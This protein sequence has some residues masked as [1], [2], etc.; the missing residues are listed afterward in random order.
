LAAATGGGNFVVFAGTGNSVTVTNLTP[1]TTYYFAVFEFNGT[2]TS[3]DY[4]TTNPATGSQTT[5]AAFQVSGVVRSRGGAGLSGVTV[6]LASGD[7]ALA[8]SVTDANGNYSFPNVQAGG[9]YTVTPSSTSFIFSPPSASFNALAAN[10]TADFTGLPRVIISE[11]R[12]HGVDPDGAGAATASANEFIE[13]YNQT[14]ENVTVTGWTLR[15]SDGTTLLTLPAAII[16]ARGHYLVAGSSYGLASYAAA[17]STLAADIPD[18][19]GVALFNNNTTFDAGTRLDA[20][21]FSGVGDPNYRESAGLTPAGGVVEDGE[22]SFVRRLA[23]GGVPADTD[24]NEADFLLVS[25]NGG[26][27]SSRQ[28]GLGAPGPENTSSPIQRNSQVTL[29]LLDPAHSSSESPNRTRDFTSDPANN[30][31]FGT[32]AIRRTLMNNTGAS[33]TR[34][35][36]RIVDVTTYP[37]PAGTADLRARTSGPVT[38]SVSGV[39]RTV[40]GTTLEEPPAQASG[41][42]NNSTLAAGTVTLAAPLANSASIDLQFLLGVQASGYFRF[43]VNVEAV[44]QAPVSAS[45]HLTMG[46]PSNAVTDVNQPTNFLMEKPQYVLAYHRDRGT[47]VWT[48]WHLDSTWLGSAPRQN[49]F[50]ADTTL[51]AGWYQVQGTDY[52]GSGFDRGHMTPSADRTKTVSDNSATFLM[53]NMIPQLPANNQGPWA[54]LESYARTL[55][56]AGNEL[57]IISGGTGTQG[58]IASGHVTVPTQTWKVIMVL[59]VGT[60]DVS[61]VTTSTRLIAVIM[62][63][64]GTINTDWRTYRVSVDQ[65]E[66]LT[67]FDFFSN[68]S[69]AIQSSIEATV[70]NQ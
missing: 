6:T 49:D 10:Q 5:A 28:S 26:V 51:P 65:V 7:T 59:P 48:S 34:L 2:G 36:F 12:F 18:G 61:R 20:A 53:T 66:A 33:I 50:R 13:L 29:T 17:N 32:M 30:S 8:N 19:A 69:P 45:E 52:S 22:F 24:N 14:D 15:A 3:T 37:V 46:N 41:G 55:V 60:N 31:Q 38:V 57:Y 9:D 63:N 56:G 62:P 25:T 11:F 39:D 16:P 4:L 43:F 42:G 44:T 40:Q 47:P 1:S 70:D 64:S 35:R 58:T 27:Y 68:V 67:G 54:D 23:V 21:G